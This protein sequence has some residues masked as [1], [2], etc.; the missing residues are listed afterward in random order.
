[1]ARKAFT[2]RVFERSRVELGL[3]TGGIGMQAP[4]DRRCPARRE[5]DR[6]VDTEQGSGSK[7]DARITPVGGLVAEFG[8][9]RGEDVAFEAKSLR[10][11]PE[12]LAV[13]Q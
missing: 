6:L 9:A 8:V 5:I 12:D 11:A 1:M 7:T 4:K 2:T 10:E 13:G 3:A